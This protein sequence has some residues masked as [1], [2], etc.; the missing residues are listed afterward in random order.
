[1]MWTWMAV[2]T[3]LAAQTPGEYKDRAAKLEAKAMKHEAEADRMEKASRSNPMLYKWPAMVKGPIERE[4]RL[5]MEARRAAAESL[6]LAAKEEKS[7]A[8]K[9]EVE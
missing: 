7:K 4:R 9:P 8:T 5:A 3:V 2:S 6:E 1:M